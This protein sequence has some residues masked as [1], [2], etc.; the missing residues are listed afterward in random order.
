MRLKNLIIGD[1]KFQIKYGFYFIYLILTILYV[2][3]LFALPESI[4]EKTSTILI[5]TD[6]AAMGMFFMGSIILLEKSQR[7]LNSLVVSPIKVW[8]YV[9]SKCISLGLISTIVAVIIALFA[10]NHNL[11]LVILGTFFGS[12]LFTLL[13]IIVGSNVANLNQFILATVP[14]EIV[15]FV[16]PLF[17]YFG[18]EKIFLIAHPGVFIIN[19][20]SNNTDN[21][22]TSLFGLIAWIALLFAIATSVTSKMFN[23]VGGVKL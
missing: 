5:F 17:Y 23:S 11:F 20:I 19:F 16:P 14:F 7:V 12:V 10:G 18:Y 6:P 2:C 3:L 9:A 21:V 22:I 13:G 1:I 15:C 8:E 4:R